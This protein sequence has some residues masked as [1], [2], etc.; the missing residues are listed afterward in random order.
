MDE[1]CMDDDEHDNDRQ[2]G[3]GTEGTGR[4]QTPVRI[5][6]NK[7]KNRLIFLLHPTQK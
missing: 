2:R 1:S 5:E 4:Q 6:L 7:F 3:L